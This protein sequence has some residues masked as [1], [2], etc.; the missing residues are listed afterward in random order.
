MAQIDKQFVLGITLK[1][2][3]KEKAM[4]YTKKMHLEEDGYLD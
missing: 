4:R 3:R 1:G 2:P